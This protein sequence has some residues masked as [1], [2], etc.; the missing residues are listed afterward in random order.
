MM[1]P[2]STTMF[3]AAPARALT[4]A[5]A[6]AL[7]ACGGVQSRTDGAN[8]A[9][10]QGPPAV[11]A[12]IRGGDVTDLPPGLVANGLTDDSVVVV[13]GSDQALREMRPPWRLVVR[14]GSPASYAKVRNPRAVVAAPTEGF[15]A[16]LKLS[17]K[18]AALEDDALAAL[19]QPT[20]FR[21]ATR[22][23]DIVTGLAAVATLDALLALDAVESLR[24]ASRVQQR[25]EP[26]PPPTP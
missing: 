19:L 25:S 11:V 18:G 1:A 4:L 22:A 14:F 21:M 16:L 3:A 2:R 12:S 13:R 7:S 23:G 17:A 6:M 26:P 20:G 9:T 10:K 5:L 15:Q 24:A 8:A